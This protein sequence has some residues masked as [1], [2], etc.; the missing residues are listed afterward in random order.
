MPH[1]RQRAALSG[2][3]RII[4][5]CFA[6]T[7]LTHA[8]AFD[9]VFFDAK[10][11]PEG[12]LEGMIEGEGTS[13][14]VAEG[15][16]EGE[17][18]IDGEGQLEGEGITEGALEGELEGAAEGIVEGGV[19]G[20]AEGEF[21]GSIEG[22]M[23]GEGEAVDPLT[24][25]V[26]VR[27]DAVLPVGLE[28][29]GLSWETAFSSL[30]EGLDAAASLGRPEVWVARG[31]YLLENTV[32]G[33]LRLQPGVAVYGGF[34]GDET[35]RSQRDLLRNVCVIDGSRSDAGQ[36][37]LHVVQGAEGARLD[38]FTLRGGVGDGGGLLAQGVTMSVWNCIFRDNRAS[39]FGGGLLAVG[40]ADVALIDCVFR[41]NT[42][43]I[44][45]GGLSASN[46][47]VTMQNLLFYRNAT[48]GNGGGAYFG[49]GANAFLGSCR[50]TENTAADGAGLASAGSTSL[51]LSGCWV[52]R[53]TASLLGG[54]AQ[55]VN[56][57]S[58]ALVNSVFS[59]NRADIHGGAINNQETSPLIAQCTFSG[60]RA[61][62]R[63]WTIYN[64]G[65][66]SPNIV[67]T[68]IANTGGGEIIGNFDTGQPVINYSLI[69][70]LPAPG[71]QNLSGDPRF[72]DEANE[73]YGLGSGSP[74]VDTGRDVSAEP[75]GGEANDYVGNPR[76]VDGD[77]FGAISGDGSEYDLGA[78]EAPFNG[79]VPDS[80]EVPK[81][82]HS[83]DVNQDFVFDLSE[84]L[85]VIQL[86]N[87]GGYGCNPATEDGFEPVGDASDC[88]PHSSDYEGGDFILTLSELLRTVQLFNLRGYYLCPGL[89]EDNFCG[90][91]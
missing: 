7:G 49:V 22:M 29:D 24:E 19:E 17:G 76:G 68:I 12:S 52:G 8:A 63:G 81:P 6:T 15:T 89:N 70:G 11:V 67:N 61:Q 75:F 2:W 64:Q 54:G 66:S 60:N 86:Y 88:D 4:L 33:T 1:S 83:A 69:E 10:G 41:D 18:A 16:P 84:L 23:E 38:G 73:V 45:G 35:A 62:E 50:F 71:T 53:N 14:G 31:V 5:V 91:V 39:R 58:V 82:E 65:A 85:R 13:E 43:D 72:I 79:S 80:R 44:N 40:G 9:S 37:T 87:A 57:A 3:L 21:E 48:G 25:V 51:R 78:F 36:P 77:G 28:S 32:D 26:Y 47:T 56:T 30:Q 46:A 74:A 34:R 27:R 59:L 20:S 55:F 42:A 90:A